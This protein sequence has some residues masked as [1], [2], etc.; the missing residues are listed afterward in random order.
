MSNGLWVD[1][2]W[3]PL[4]KICQHTCCTVFAAR[5]QISALDTWEDGT[6]VLVRPD[7]FNSRIPDEVIRDLFMV[8]ARNPH[9]TFKV[10][11]AEPARMEQW[12]GTWASSQVADWMAKSDRNWPCDNIELGIVVRDQDQGEYDLASLLGAPAVRRFVILNDI[13][14]P[15]N[16]TDIECPGGIYEATQVKSCSMCDGKEGACRYGR[17]NAL[18]LGVHEVLI[19]RQAEPFDDLNNWRSDVVAQCQAHGVSIAFL[20]S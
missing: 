19:G 12:F 14:E 18:A 8:M 10:L 17:Y 7:L 15:I 2:V 16:L 6:R 20:P 11:T 4:G 13:I 5:S 3:S 9:L 1:R